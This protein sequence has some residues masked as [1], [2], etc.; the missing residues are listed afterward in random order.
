MKS[1]FEIDKQ[2]LKDLNVFGVTKG[3]KS[4]FSL[5]DNTFC[6]GGRA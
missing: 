2:T 1:K 3:D 6:M 5:F 4:L